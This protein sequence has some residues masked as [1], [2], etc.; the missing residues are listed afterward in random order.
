MTAY[1]H[2][3]VQNN[4]CC[5]FYDFFAFFFTIALP[6]ASGEF[7]TSSP[8]D[9][10]SSS[11]CSAAASV[12]AMLVY[13]GLLLLSVEVVVEDAFPKEGVVLLSGLV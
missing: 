2:L 9:Y 4:S 12:L 10:S 11:S 13:I 8:D 1:L 3:L 5:G 7:P 6:L